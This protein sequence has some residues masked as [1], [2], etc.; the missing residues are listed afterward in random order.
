[1]A[2][3]E[4]LAGPAHPEKADAAFQLA[5]ERMDHARQHSFL[6][7]VPSR[8]Q[9][10]HLSQRLLKMSRKPLLAC[11]SILT[12]DEWINHLSAAAPSPSFPT[13]F[14][15]IF[16]EDALSQ[17]EAYKLAGGHA[18]TAGL[19]D[20]IDRLFRDIEYRGIAVEDLPSLS[21]REKELGTLYASY[22]ECIAQHWNTTGHVLRTLSP[23]QMAPSFKHNFPHLELLIV[24]GFNAWPSHVQSL[25]DSFIQHLQEIHITLD[26]EKE[27]PQL[28]AQTTHLYHFFKERAANTQ[29]YTSPEPHAA[30]AIAAQLFLRSNIQDGAPVH[31]HS[32]DDR[33]DEVEC[34]ARQIRQLC[35]E[36]NVALASTRIAFADLDRYL[37]LLY[38]VLPQHGIPFHHLRG[39]PL[40]AT[41]LSKVVYAILDAVLE[42]YSRRSLL[43]LLSLPWISL[44]STDGIPFPL[45]VFDAWA[46]NLSSTEG[47]SGWLQAVD[48]R[49]AYLERERENLRSGDPVAED[50]DDPV[51]RRQKLEADLAALH[52]LRGALENLFAALRPF[53]R[54]LTID[55]FRDSLLAAFTAFGVPQYLEQ[56]ASTSGNRNAPSPVLTYTHFTQLLDIFCATAPALERPRW[57]VRELSSLLRTA[58]AQ[59]FIA[60]DKRAGVEIVDLRES[61][62]MP[63]EILFLGGLIEGEFPRPFTSDLFFDETQRQALN[64]DNNESSTAA[65]RLLFYQACCAPRQHLFLSHPCREGN[66]ALNRSPFVEEVATRLIDTSTRQEGEMLYDDA[67]FTRADLHRSIGIGLSAPNKEGAE[68]QKLFATSCA[69]AELS[70]ALNR[71]HHGL[72]VEKL[73]SS[74]A[75][76]TPYEGIIADETTRTAISRRLGP[77]H[78]FS[79][80]QLETYGRCPFRFFAERLLKIKSLEDPEADTTAID[81]GNLVHRILYHFYDERRSENGARAVKPDDLAQALTAM[82]RIGFREAEAMKLGG[83]FWERELER[84]LGS[85]QAHSREGVIERFLRLEAEAAEPAS[86]AHFE[87]SF[88]SY[89]GMGPRDPHSASAA[90]TIEEQGQVVRLL[91]KI[92]RID[93]TDDGRFV[94][95][96]Y[97]TGYPPR[98]SDIARGLNLQL[99][100]YLLAV[101][102]LLGESGL[103]QGMAA[104]Y[105][106]LRDLEECGRSALFADEQGRHSVYTAA[107]KRGLLPHDAFRQTLAELRQHVATYAASMRTGIFNVTTHDPTRICP[108]CPYAQSC[109]LAPRRMRTLKREG[110]L[111]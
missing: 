79:T 55:L 41:P 45:E 61:R 8:W 49:S 35:G 14:S 50:I 9:A 75:G 42:N 1:M 72:T 30:K 78:A 107:S 89:E 102:N 98:V 101:E 67:I 44:P 56:H 10:R 84:L 82:R 64:L 80:T 106:L 43:R 37:P 68:A 47:R 73:R 66:T 108:H 85:D 36:Q 32:R 81:R 59:T 2:R 38:E 28:Y 105:L 46:R 23:T 39:I 83:F 111:K 87:L 86:P 104:A 69:Q 20:S 100:L 4:L 109:R 51:Q 34:I 94:V 60:P 48:R 97:K 26:Y 25:F 13:A 6:W 24:S 7:L 110:R 19:A 63:C 65:D 5:L 88:G 93:R 70:P 57:S 12:L 53:E 99:P 74:I 92:D 71:L 16:V 18:V 96:D 76:L 33:L 15:R 3:L 31:I 27:R 95:Y 91:G 90:F 22:L 52:P 17:G 58:M 103:Q 21:V 62:S 29:F 11:S 77:H 40:A 54:P